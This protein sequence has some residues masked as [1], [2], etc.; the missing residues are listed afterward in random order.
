MSSKPKHYYGASSLSHALEN[1]TSPVF[2][3]RGF[4][5]KRVLTDWHHIV[6]EVIARYSTPQKLVFPSDVKERGVLHVDVYDSAFATEIHYLGP[7]IM[8]KI[9]TYFGYPAVARLHITQKPMVVEEQTPEYIAPVKD[10]PATLEADIEGITDEALQNA[11]KGLGRL[12]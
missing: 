3:R 12:V 9:A 7:L 2:K 11:L 10:L 8:E 1:I 6:G 5:E 4:A